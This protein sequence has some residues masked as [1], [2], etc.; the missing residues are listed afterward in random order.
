MIFGI[1][2][3]FYKIKKYNIMKQLRVKN[4]LK[5]IKPINIF[6]AVLKQ[7]LINKY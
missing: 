4:K 2:R 7:N 6:I 5:I 3:F 1:I